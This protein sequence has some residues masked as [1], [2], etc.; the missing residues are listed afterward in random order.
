MKNPVTQCDPA[1]CGYWSSPGVSFASIY[2]GHVDA[3][4]IQVT[5]LAGLVDD[6]V[7]CAHD[8]ESSL[9]NLHKTLGGLS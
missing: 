9:H 2:V 6:S 3:L 4:V 8:T 7:V 5:F 1:K